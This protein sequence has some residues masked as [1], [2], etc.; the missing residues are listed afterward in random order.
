MRQR[1]SRPSVVVRPEPRDRVLYEQIKR[2]ASRR[3][4]APSS[5]YRSAWIVKTYKQRGGR[6]LTPRSPAVSRQGLIRWSREQWVNLNAPRY[7]RQGR[8]RGYE[9]C[10][11]SR[12]PRSVSRSPYPLC[13]PSRRV[14]RQ[15]PLTYQEVS[16]ARIRKL[17]R[18]KQRVR[19]RGRV[20][21]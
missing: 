7:D 13:R 9:P 8:P 11:R 15:T 5:W 14:S 10:G 18:Q 3:F 12:T 1:R 19:S 17:N 21:F 4:E 6:Y 2:E 16:V 20:R